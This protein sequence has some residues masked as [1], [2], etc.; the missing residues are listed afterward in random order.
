MAIDERE[1]ILGMFPGTDPALWPPGEVLYYRRGE[2][3]VI[4]EKPLEVVLTPVARPPSP[5]PVICEAC[6]RQLRGEDG[7]FFRVRLE[8]GEREV[9]RYFALC[10]DTDTC[11][12][13]ARPEV[14]RKLIR[15]GIL[16]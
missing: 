10:E 14:L 11:R 8:L 16:L 2:L 9:F 1:L 4:A 7:R 6:H 13:R 12:E 5:K 15:K 3:V